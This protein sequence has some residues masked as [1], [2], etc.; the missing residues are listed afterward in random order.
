MGARTEGA[1][2]VRPDEPA[3]ARGPILVERCHDYITKVSPKEVGY[4]RAQ[5]EAEGG[6]C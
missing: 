6:S 1:Y 5:R 2:R 4:A 3:I